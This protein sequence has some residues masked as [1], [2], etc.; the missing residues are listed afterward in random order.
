VSASEG[1]ADASVGWLYPKARR[2]SWR[3]SANCRTVL[4][5][6]PLPTVIADRTNAA[7]GSSSALAISAGRVQDR[8]CQR[9]SVLACLCLAHRASNRRSS[10]GAPC[11]AGENEEQH[12]D[13]SNDEQLNGHRHILQ[14]L[15]RPLDLALRRPANAR[16]RIAWLSACSVSGSTVSVAVAEDRLVRSAV[17]G[18]GRQ[19][20]R[21]AWSVSRDYGC[22]SRGRRR[23]VAGRAAEGREPPA[24]LT[25]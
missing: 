12:D 23:A 21:D 18:G 9:R 24:R 5:A 11:E 1:S 15:A 22:A 17:R 3:S 7:R 14:W 20:Q 16:S 2:C 25:S 8:C 6:D 13:R 10:A 4:L 19:V